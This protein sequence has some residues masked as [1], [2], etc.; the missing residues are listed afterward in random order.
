MQ[1]PEA[2]SPTYKVVLSDC[3]DLLAG[4]P[5]ASVDLILTDPAYS[6]MNQHLKLGRG[7]I[8]GVYKDAGEEGGK[9]FSEFHDD[10]ETYLR[11]LRECYRVLRPD[12]HVYIMFDSFSFI[13]LSLLV[14][15]VFSIKQV[16]VWDKVNMG[17]GHYMRRRHEFV[18]LASKGH[19]AP[20]NHSTPDVIRV[21]RL[22]RP[23]YPTQKPVALFSTLL[24]VS[25]EPGYTVCDPFVGAG[26]TA[27]AA[28]RA[29]CNF[30]GGDTNERAVQL[31]EDRC[32]H[33]LRTGEDLLERAPGKPPVS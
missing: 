11:L 25:A 23:V 28:L 7:R 2:A 20:N 8:V 15:Q 26:S 24:S 31:T 22:S 4:L 17:M 9:W 3:F 32:A 29:G 21:K 27:I 13:H 19:R 1:D 18:L 16:A 14:E 10:P 12:R 6:G 30:V 5:D 33:F